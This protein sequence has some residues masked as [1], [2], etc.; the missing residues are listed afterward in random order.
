[1]L[2]VWIERGALYKYT[3]WVGGDGK[4]AVAPEYVGEK[5]ECFQK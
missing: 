4:N 3:Q 2:H 1:M 5:N